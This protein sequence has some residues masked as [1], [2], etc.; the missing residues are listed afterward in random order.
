[1][2]SR[3]KGGTE[4]EGMGFEAFKV[5]IILREE[6]FNPEDG[7][8]KFLRALVNIYLTARRQIQRDSGLHRL[9]AFEN[10]V[11]RRIL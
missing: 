7:G 6:F 4:I 10:R 9:K 5:V 3:V 11:L 2:V 1:L 8:R